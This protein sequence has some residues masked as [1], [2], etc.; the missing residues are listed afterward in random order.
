MSKKI[1][2]SKIPVI[3][4]ILFDPCVL[5]VEYNAE[6]KELRAWTQRALTEKSRS[7]ALQ[8]HNLIR[9]CFPKLN[10]DFTCSH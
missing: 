9:C 1:F 4:D 2:T 5:T 3:S 8:I 6:W 10:A 7:A